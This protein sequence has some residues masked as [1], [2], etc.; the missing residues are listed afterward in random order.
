MSYAH[1]YQF[2]RIMYTKLVKFAATRVVFKA[3]NHQSAFSVL[4]ELMTVPKIPQLATKQDT[5]DIPQYFP[6]L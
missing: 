4:E 5:Q 2:I 6:P 3:K 1:E